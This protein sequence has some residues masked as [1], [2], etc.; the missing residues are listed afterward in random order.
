MITFVTD[1]IPNQ[2]EVISAHGTQ[3]KVNLCQAKSDKDFFPPK[4]RNLLIS[5]SEK[6]AL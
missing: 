2:T 3:L 4:N 5:A 6:G 1:T